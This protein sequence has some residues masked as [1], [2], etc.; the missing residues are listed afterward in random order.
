MLEEEDDEDEYSASACEIMQRRSSSRRQS[1]RKRRPSS[2]FSIEAEA[3]L[4]RRSS[5]YTISSGEL[6]LLIHIIIT[7]DENDHLKK[8]DVSLTIE[9]STSMKLKS[10][11]A[12]SW[13][14]KMWQNR[15]LDGGER[16]P[17][18]DIRKV[19]VAQRGVERSEATAVA[20]S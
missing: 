2:P 13:C 1:R 7:L 11:K 8:K 10:K 5:A 18:A 16:K 19:E 15:D 6:V 9:W 20:A 17:G 3:M 14:R 12:F 4:R